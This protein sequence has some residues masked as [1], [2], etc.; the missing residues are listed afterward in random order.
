MPASLRLVLGFGS[1]KTLDAQDLRR[2]LADK[3]GTSHASG[4]PRFTGTPLRA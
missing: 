2:A 1:A 4:L 3:S